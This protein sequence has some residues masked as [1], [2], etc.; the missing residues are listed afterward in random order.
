[1]KMDS[2][3]IWRARGEARLGYPLALLLGK[4]GAA[5]LAAARLRQSS[6][7]PVFP[8]QGRRLEG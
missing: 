5:E 3:Y 4:T 7:H 2:G 8:A 1:M 6:L